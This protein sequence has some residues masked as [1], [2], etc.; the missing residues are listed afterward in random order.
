M[1]SGSITERNVPLANRSTVGR[2]MPARPWEQGSYGSNYGGKCVAL[3]P[4]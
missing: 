3:Y 4:V 2:P 1:N